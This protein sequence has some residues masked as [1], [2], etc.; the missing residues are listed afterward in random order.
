MPLQKLSFVSSE[1]V[2]IRKDGRPQQ[3]L[4]RTAALQSKGWPR[5]LHQLRFAPTRSC[6]QYLP[7]FVMRGDKETTTEA[8]QSAVQG[9]SRV[10]D[11]RERSLGTTF[12]FHP[13]GRA[14][15]QRDRNQSSPE[16][17]GWVGAGSL[18]PLPQQIGTALSR[19]EDLAL[20]S[21]GPLIFQL[22]R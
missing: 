11:G 20:P 17:G 5:G 10:R 21:Q 16:S 8:K 6:S 13:L 12:H 2:Q 7:G 1:A 18:L 19:G 15:T 14:L 4:W 9:S 3:F 22:G